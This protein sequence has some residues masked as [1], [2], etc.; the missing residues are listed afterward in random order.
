LGKSLQTVHVSFRVFVL[1]TELVCEV[2]LPAFLCAGKMPSLQK[3][4]SGGAKSIIKCREFESAGIARSYDSKFL[5]TCCYVKA[6]QN[7]VE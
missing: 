2:V 6:K 7:C 5:K 4:P 3:I 1:L